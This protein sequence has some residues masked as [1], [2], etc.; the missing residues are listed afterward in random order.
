MRGSHFGR[1]SAISRVER[2]P[3]EKRLDRRLARSVDAGLI[4]S[5]QAPAT[6]EGQCS[7]SYANAHQHQA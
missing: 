4:L 2:P 7:D 6:A 1:K 5:S 3:H